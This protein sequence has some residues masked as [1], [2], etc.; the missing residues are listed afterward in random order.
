MVIQDR[1]QVEIVENLECF[2]VSTKT[3]FLSLGI[4]TFVFSAMLA[5]LIALLTVSYLTCPSRR[6]WPT[7]RIA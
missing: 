7:L 3:N 2:I 4:E 6:P 1:Q 5:F